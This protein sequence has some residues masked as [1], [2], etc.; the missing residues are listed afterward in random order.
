M[1]DRKS[2]TVHYRK[3]DSSELG[4]MTLE[5]AFRNAMY[6]QIQESTFAHKY[7][8]RVWKNLND[9]L[10]INY[11]TNKNQ[12]DA[13]YM[14]GDLIHFTAGHLQALFDKQNDAPTASVYQMP[15]PSQKEYIHSLM[16]WLIKDDHIFVIQSQSLKTDSLEN[17]LTWFL[18]GKG[19]TQCQDFIHTIPK[20]ILQSKF[21]FGENGGDIDDIKQVV[22]G[23]VV[24]TTTPQ[25]VTNKT[26]PAKKMRKHNLSIRSVQIKP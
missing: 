1:A 26:F 25:P 20:V 19:E 4:D 13:S 22:I 16:Y 23:G 17:Y 5:Q 14:F 3:F 9:N 12:D 8:L 15:A 18:K 6:E 10:F 2:V 7:R 21:D 24:P 11:F